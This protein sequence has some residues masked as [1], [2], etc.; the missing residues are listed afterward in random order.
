MYVLCGVRHCVIHAEHYTLVCVASCGD[1]AA[2]VAEAMASLIAVSS[3][4][5][6]IEGACAATSSGVSA[7]ADK[8]AMPEVL[9]KL[10]R[11]IACCSGFMILFSLAVIDP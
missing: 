2:L 11:S 10:R 5:V 6:F 8:A 9:I 1:G 3:V 4:A 7:A